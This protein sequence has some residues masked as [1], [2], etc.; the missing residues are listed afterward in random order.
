MIKFNN[1]NYLI[2]IFIRVFHGIGFISVAATVSCSNAKSKITFRD[3]RSPSGSL[4]TNFI[5]QQRAYHCHALLTAPMTSGPLTVAD[6]ES[7]KT[8]F[9]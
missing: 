1:Y 5:P 2:A 9:S 4:K 8:E 3:P 6:Y 7:R